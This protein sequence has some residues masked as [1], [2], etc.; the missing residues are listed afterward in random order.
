MVWS[1]TAA[2]IINQIAR[3]FVSL[4][5]KSFSDDEPTALSFT[6][7]S[8]DFGDTSK[9]TH[10]WPALISRRTMLAP[11][12]PRPTIPSCIDHP[13]SQPSNVNWPLAFQLFLALL[14][15]FSFQCESRLSLL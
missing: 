9:T 8:T 11:I 3:G 12:L 10:S 6:T 13:L 4:A 15:L 5:A 14:E 1:T 7:S 2:G